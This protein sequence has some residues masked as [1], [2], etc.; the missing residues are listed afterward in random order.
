MLNNAAINNLFIIV[1]HIFFMFTTAF[2]VFVPLKEEKITHSG[3][4]ELRFNSVIDVD[5]FFGNF[6]LI[7]EVVSCIKENRVVH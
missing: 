6:S 2:A 1:T 7:S 3:S 4:G 5:C